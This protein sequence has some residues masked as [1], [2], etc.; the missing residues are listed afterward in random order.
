[1]DARMVK[2][3]PVKVPADAAGVDPAHGKLQ[4]IHGPRKLQS[5][6]PRAPDDDV[7]RILQRPRHSAIL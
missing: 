2:E 5:P 6:W 1:M 3:P 4:P 7:D